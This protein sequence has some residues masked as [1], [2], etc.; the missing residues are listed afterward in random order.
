MSVAPS[1][2]TTCQSAPPGRTRPLSF[3]PFTLPPAMPT[4]RRS[5]YG[6]LPRVTTASSSASMVKI[7]QFPSMVVRPTS[8]PELSQCLDVM[9]T[10]IFKREDAQSGHSGAHV[11]ARRRGDRIRFL[12]AAVR[13][14]RLARFDVSRRRNNSVALGATADE[15]PLFD[16]F[17]RPLDPVFLRSCALRRRL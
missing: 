1:L 17:S 2:R 13:R 12:F 10:L 3:E 4:K 16:F 6:V 15:Q 14:S 5:P 9:S 11:A 8:P 7:G